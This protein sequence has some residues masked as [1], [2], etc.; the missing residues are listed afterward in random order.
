MFPI[1]HKSVFVLDENPSFVSTQCQEH[2]EFDKSRSGGLPAISK[3][4]WTCAVESV[5]EYCRIIW[6]LYPDGERLISFARCRPNRHALLSWSEEDQ[7]LPALMRA[8]IDTSRQV[9]TAGSSGDS[10]LLVGLRAAVAV[11]GQE[12]EAQR[13][14]AAVIQNRG[15]ILCLSYFRSDAQIMAIQEKVAAFVEEHNALVRNSSGNEKSRLLTVD[16]TEVVF[17]NTHPLND[18]TASSRIVHKPLHQVAPCLTCE[19]HS[20]PSG[21]VLSQ[22]MLSL[23]LKQYNLSSTTVTGIPMKEEQN[24]SSSANYDVE[25]VHPEEVHQDMVRS[26]VADALKVPKEGCEYTTIPLKWCTPR[27]NAVE[28]HYTLVACRVTPVDVNSRPSNCLS[29]FL[30]AGR[31]VMLEMV[32]PKNKVMSHMLSSHNSELYIHTLASSR[33]TIED[34]PSISEGTGGRVTDYRINDFGEFMRQNRLVRCDA[35]QV[36]CAS[37]KA[38]HSLCRQTVY[39]PIVIGNTIIFNL[40]Q[41]IQQ[42]LDLIPK[43]K[44]TIDEVNDCKNAVYQ[45]VNM[46]SKGVN[47]TVPG[48]QSKGKGPK[49]E[50]LYKLLYRELTHFVANFAAT[51]EHQQV[52]S[53]LNDVHSGA[54]DS[55]ESLTRKLPKPQAEAG[56]SKSGGG[57]DAAAAG[58]L[59]WKESHF[60]GHSPDSPTSIDRK[61]QRTSSP[62]SGFD[63]FGPEETL[64]SFWTKRLAAEAGRHH[65]EFA[66]R[67]ES[68]S[69]IATLYLHMN[70]KTSDQT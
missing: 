22:K 13:K 51:P 32:R 41:Y 68:S 28:M 8:F 4:L 55:A 20:T 5:A 61:K 29:N 60:N 46:E 56:S 42:L 50:E 31:T 64:L 67:L 16:Q 33:C 2:L 65:P 62:G 37:E 27:S 69:S 25:I 3:S 6:D 17:I 34:P 12:S 21:T 44:L 14:A 54:G 7:S 49:R 52:L 40:Q 63:A 10:D 30:L 11:L 19:V 48:L 15:R 57:R 23:A 43:D 18:N 9:T 45:I 70:E 26:G 38:K 59:Q 58:D 24:A 36:P 35:T 1:S 47:L 53:C 66:G 39:W